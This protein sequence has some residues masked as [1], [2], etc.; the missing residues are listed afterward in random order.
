MIEASQ[1]DRMKKHN[2]LLFSWNDFGGL[3]ASAQFTFFKGSLEA[4][5]AQVCNREIQA[6]IVN[7][8]D[9]QPGQKVLEA[10]CGLGRRAQLMAR[11]AN[12]QVE[13]TAIDKS[14]KA[15]ELA[16]KLSG[17]T[18][19]IYQQANVESLPFES[20]YFDV[21]TADRLLICFKDP[22][23]ALKEMY[24]VLKPGGRLVVTD[25][26]PASIFIAP[27]D[28]EMHQVFMDIYMP[29][30][31]N[32][33]IGRSLPALFQKIG[34]EHFNVEVDAS[35][36][37]SFSHLEKIIPMQQVLDGGIRAGYLSKEKADQWL[38]GLRQ[39]SD[40]GTFLYAISMISIFGQKPL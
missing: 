10:G 9:L 2:E 20:G 23:P 5:D 37:R 3:D 4:M 24:R 26:D 17:E 21:V 22:L 28:E 38:V 7:R 12:H 32:R 33:Y 29:S 40:E 11:E 36:E 30:F 6:K 27:S 39:A 8:M 18:N 15:L 14:E 16:K 1:E 13:V 31:S 35:Y 19:L 34:I 25:F